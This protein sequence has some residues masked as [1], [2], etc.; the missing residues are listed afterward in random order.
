MMLWVC[1]S[2]DREIVASM[3]YFQSVVEARSYCARMSGRWFKAYL[4]R[5]STSKAKLDR[6]LST[7]PSSRAKAYR[8]R[9]RSG[10]C[11][12]RSSASGLTYRLAAASIHVL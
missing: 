9:V 6:I 2:T 5:G 10:L 3:H 11:S 8:R 12:G 7:S 1:Q 4:H